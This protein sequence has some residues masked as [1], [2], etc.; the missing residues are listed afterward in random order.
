MS[1]QPATCSRELY[2]PVEGEEW[3]HVEGPCSLG[4]RVVGVLEAEADVDRNRGDA[5]GAY[6]WRAP[7]VARRS[8]YPIQ[9]DRRN[10]ARQVDLRRSDADSPCGAGHRAR[11]LR[12]TD[13]ASTR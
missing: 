7:R 6:S 10:G 3:A 1:R 13:T 4:D 12:A 8:G 11:C 2:V 9:I 5:A